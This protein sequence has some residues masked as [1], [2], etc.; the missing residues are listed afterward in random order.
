MNMWIENIVNK[1]GLGCMRRLGV[2]LLKFLNR[3][4][5]LEVFLFWISFEIRFEYISFII[6]VFVRFIYW[7]VDRIIL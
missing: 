4:V 7:V 5:L 3:M 2:C 1:K 6:G